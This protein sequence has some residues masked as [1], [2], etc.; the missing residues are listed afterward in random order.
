M[1][2]LMLSSG[3]GPGVVARLVS[4]SAFLHPHYPGELSSTVCLAH[5]KRPAAR[6]WGPV[7]LLLGP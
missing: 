5:P 6:G 7:L 2:E 1:G 4:L 3:S